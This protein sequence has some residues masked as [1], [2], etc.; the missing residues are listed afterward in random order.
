MIVRGPER[1][2]T[3]QPGI[4]TRHC[5]SAGANY[6][7]TNISFGPL[8]GVDEHMVE[9]GAGFAEH[10]H[11]GVEIISWIAAGQLSHTVGDET[12]V[13]NAGESLIQDA[14]DTVHHSE[15]NDGGEPLRLI[16]TTLVAGSGAVFTVAKAATELQAPW[17]HLFVVEGAW[18][19]DDEQLEPGD[20]VRSTDDEP[21]TLDGTGVVLA[22][23]HPGL[24]EQ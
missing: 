1:F 8:L 23:S 20:S 6:D 24:T 3:T 17:L 2:E 21:H 15:R 7:P 11:R 14:A 13:I 5:F 19:F 12:Q 10:A 16:Q 22:L 9:P 18:Q 4:V